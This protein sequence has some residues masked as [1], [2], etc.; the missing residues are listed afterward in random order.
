MAEPSGCLVLQRFQA[1]E[2]GLPSVCP[3][4]SR[5]FAHDVGYILQIFVDHR[6]SWISSLKKNKK[7]SI[8]RAV[9]QIRDTLNAITHAVW[10]ANDDFIED[11]AGTLVAHEEGI[12]AGLNQINI[13]QW[14]YTQ[15]ALCSFFILKRALPSAYGAMK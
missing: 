9:V 5:E 13:G 2:D 11:T 15:T 7:F 4:F 8:H 12:Q 3:I 10:N 1:L 6:L 14:P